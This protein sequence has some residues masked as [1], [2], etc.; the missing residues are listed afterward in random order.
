[1]NFKE[2]I[3]N[4][5]CPAGNGV[6]TV[7]TAAD[8]KSNL[9]ETLYGSK[10]AEVVYESWLQSVEHFFNNPTPALLG[11]PSDCGGG[12]LRGANWGPLFVRKEFYQST[13]S[14][15][16]DLGDVRVI[17]HLLHDK[18]LNS[19]TISSC[20]NALYDGLDLPVSPLSILER[21]CKNFHSLFKETPLL[22]L[23]GDHS[24][25][26]PL[27]NEWIKAKRKNGKKVAIIHFDAH[28][29]LLDKRLGIDLCFGSWTYHIL[30]SLNHPSDVYQIGI[31][32]SGYDKKYWENKT[33]VH[34][35]WSD[36]I[37]Q[38]GI[39]Q[40]SRAII[41]DLK[42]KKIDELYVSFDID[43][44]DNEYV[45]A[46]GTPEPNGIE[47]HHALGI[48]KMLRSEFKITSADI[49]EVAPFLKTHEPKFSVEP[50][51]TLMVASTIAQFFEETFHG[52]S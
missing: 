27:V 38:N 15:L 20:Q 31:R 19:T 22:A 49:V 5:L 45:S 18:Y 3:F 10:E 47:P 33:G 52:H 51:S 34:Q 48:L 4:Y 41:Q 6:Y 9:H 2:E 43:V 11:V 29:D 42:K 28:T 40:I 23:G 8:K 7:N 1:M 30:K 12:I 44:I 36:E 46:T 26:F 50:E 39:E 37:K 32:S 13:H 16:F 35:Y 24:V 14:P 21:F 25:S 17:P